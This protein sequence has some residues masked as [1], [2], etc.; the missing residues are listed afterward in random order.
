MIAI[1]VVITY[2]SILLYDP[3]L[4]FSSRS[5]FYYNYGGYTYADR[6]TNC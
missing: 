3:A 6:K 5:V 1:I 2:A 4:G